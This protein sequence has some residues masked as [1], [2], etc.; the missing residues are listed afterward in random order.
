MP[1]FFGWTWALKPLKA[2]P[3][4]D[5]YNLRIFAMKFWTWPSY[6]TLQHWSSVCPMGCT[7]RRSA[8]WKA[9]R[10]AGSR[11]L[12]ECIIK[13]WVLTWEWIGSGGELPNAFWH[14]GNSCL[15][16]CSNPPDHFLFFLVAVSFQRPLKRRLLFSGF[17]EH[18]QHLGFVSWSPSGSFLHNM[19][20]GELFGENMCK[21]QDMG[22]FTLTWFCPATSPY[23]CQGV[24]SSLQDTRVLNPNRFEGMS[25]LPGFLW[26]PLPDFC[27]FWEQKPNLQLLSF[28][29]VLLVSSPTTRHSKGME[30]PTWCPIWSDFLGHQ[31]IYKKSDQ[32]ILVLQ[33][34]L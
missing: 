13:A 12:S 29:R 19:F 20:G 6:W 21:L 27:G 7:M 14:M 26:V 4:F 33:G 30:A 28:Y 24:S 1:Y 10:S 2:P 5:L 22:C 8:P 11:P 18:V 25:K 17:P 3:F 15:K 34:V 23:F 16:S 9:P 31:T 32:S